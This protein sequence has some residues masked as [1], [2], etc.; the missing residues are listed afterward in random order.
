MAIGPTKRE[1]GKLY[2]RS[3]VASALSRESTCLKRKF[4]FTGMTLNV[5]YEQIHA[6]VRF[7]GRRGN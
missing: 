4:I 2:S 3:R 5:V 7:K 6:R 1:V